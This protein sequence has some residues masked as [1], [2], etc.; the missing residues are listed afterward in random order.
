MPVL[1]VKEAKSTI[2]KPGVTRRLVHAEKLMLVVIDFDNGPWSEPEPAHFHVHEQTTYVAEGEFIF[3]CEG[4]P[5]QIL[6][7]GDMFWVLPNKKHT[8]QLL[9]K[10]VKLIDSFSPI[11]EEFLQ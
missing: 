1:K 8:V 7:A 2:V 11:R 5:D 6:S 4:E 3:F 9:S 10:T